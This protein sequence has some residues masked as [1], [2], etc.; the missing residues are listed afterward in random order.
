MSK[1]KLILEV[2]AKRLL[3][4]YVDEK[5]IEVPKP[6][7]IDLSNG[8]I[9][10]PCADCDQM[11]HVYEQVRKLCTIQNLLPRIHM[12]T[13]NGGAMVLSPDW[14]DPAGQRK[15]ETLKEEIIEAR[16]M[17]DIFTVLLF[18]HAPCGKAS[19]LN[20]TVE[21]TIRHLLK[22]KQVVKGMHPRNFVRCIIQVDWQEQ[23]VDRPEKEI[24]FI[25]NER[26]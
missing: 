12:L 5:R 24:Y 7:L 2:D 8:A 18:C 3:E 15:A 25:P 17:K 4:R 22:A 6:H 16:E 10:V 9:V 1:N 21:T 11:D 19:K 23:A 26:W 20:M 13:A 14:P